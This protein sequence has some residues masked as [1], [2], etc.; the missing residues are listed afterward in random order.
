[1]QLSLQTIAA[2]KNFVQ[3]Q[4]A[5][6]D[7]GKEE[8]KDCYYDFF[9]NRTNL[10]PWGQ[11]SDEQIWEALEKTHIKEMVCKHAMENC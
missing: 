7:K 8:E 2:N 9:P 1:M 5:W 6:L 10:D 4:L 11:Y 3:S